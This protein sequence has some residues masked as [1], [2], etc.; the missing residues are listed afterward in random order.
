LSCSIILPV[1]NAEQFLFD[2]I[3]SILNQTFTDFELIIINDGSKDRSHSIINFFQ[4]LDKRIKVF[5]VE[6]S[7]IV[8]ALNLALNNCK[9]DLIARIDADDI[10]QPDRL[11]RQINFLQD[12]ADI[13]LVGSWVKLIG[14]NAGVYKYFTTHAK[15][16]RSL[17]YSE[18]SGFAHPA[19][20]INRKLITKLYY[21][22]TLMHVEDIDLWMRLLQQNLKFANIP[23]CL[24][25]Y[26]I[27]TNNISKIN[28]K[29]Q[30][31]N[32]KKLIQKPTILEKFL[33]LYDRLLLKFSREQ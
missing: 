17:R 27:H 14:T 29:T 23:V 6:N 32:R 28:Q 20:M 12:N 30:K 18:G 2:C 26:R 24:T 4:Q 16:E 31:E 5:H 33:S 3:E 9:N 8:A 7:G 11:Q 1:Y 19:V 13:A 22:D 25:Y 21:S 10:M 15:I